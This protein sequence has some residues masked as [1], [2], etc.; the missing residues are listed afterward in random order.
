[1]IQATGHA[2]SVGEAVSKECFKAPSIR[3]AT[4]QK[5]IVV[6][7]IYFQELLRLTRLLE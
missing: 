7:A 1:M 5:S 2:V 3:L 4:G 6:A